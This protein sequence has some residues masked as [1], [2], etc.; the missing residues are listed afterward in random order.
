[1]G[2]ISA[3]SPVMPQLIFMLAMIVDRDAL[4]NGLVFTRQM[5]AAS[6]LADLLQGAS[7]PNSSVQNTDD[8]NAFLASHLSV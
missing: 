7:S 4:L 2:Y 5:A 8:F 3:P 6:P 1:M